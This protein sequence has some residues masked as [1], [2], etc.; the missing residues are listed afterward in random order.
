MGLAFFQDLIALLA[1]TILWGFQNT[2]LGLPDPAARVNATNA[3]YSSTVPYTL[4]PTPHLTPDTRLGM[5]YNPLALA[6]FGKF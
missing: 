6:V 2:M 5:W 3:T 1:F 4:H